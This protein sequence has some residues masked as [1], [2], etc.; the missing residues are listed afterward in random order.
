MMQ[1][2][3]IKRSGRSKRQ[4]L[5]LDFARRRRPFWRLSYGCKAKDHLFAETLKVLKSKL[6]LN[7]LLNTRFQLLS[8][9]TRR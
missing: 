3:I 8:F 9:L 4:L 5:L 6:L 1:I 2:P 7:S